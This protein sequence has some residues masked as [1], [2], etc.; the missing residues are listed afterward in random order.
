MS[1]VPPKLRAGIAA[2]LI[3]GGGGAAYTYI[4]RNTSELLRHEYVQAVGGG[5]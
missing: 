3:A 5:R 1:K 2:V 4:D